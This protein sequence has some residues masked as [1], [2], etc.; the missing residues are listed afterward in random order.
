MAQRVDQRGEARVLATA[1]GVM[2]VL[3]V[4]MVKTALLFVALLLQRA[5]LMAVVVE[6]EAVAAVPVDLATAAMVALIIAMLLLYQP[7]QEQAAVA[8]GQQ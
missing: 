3:P 7:I 1:A 8:A 6:L 4:P 2:V 5:V